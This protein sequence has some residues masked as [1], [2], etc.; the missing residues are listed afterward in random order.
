MQSVTK[1]HSETKTVPFGDG[2]TITIRNNTPVLNP[3]ERERRK[4]DIEQRLYSV[5]SKY[6]GG[7][8]TA[9]KHF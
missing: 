8:R 5:F 6:G 9:G 7:S 4:R 3:K 2:R 1:Y